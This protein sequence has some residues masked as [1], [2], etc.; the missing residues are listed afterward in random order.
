MFAGQR[1]S[2]SD[3][4]IQPHIVAAA[5]VALHYQQPAASARRPW[6]VNR[7]VLLQLDAIV[8]NR[9]IG[10]RLP[11]PGFP[12]LTRKFALINDAGCDPGADQRQHQVAIFSP[13][14]MSQSSLLSALDPVD[15]VQSLDNS[16]SRPPRLPQG[17]QV[18]RPRNDQ[19]GIRWL[20]RI[21]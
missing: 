8:D 15:S 16:P 17:Q 21:V 18:L 10:P 1:L 19:D 2:Q 20:A 14:E 13:Q 7:L 6:P 12:P 9:S 4:A 5:Q 11:I 3:G